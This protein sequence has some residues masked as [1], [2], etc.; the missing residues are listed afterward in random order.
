MGEKNLCDYSFEAFECFWSEMRKYESRIAQLDIDFG[1]LESEADELFK[2]LEDD[3]SKNFNFDNEF[4]KK[5]I[6]LNAIL[7][8]FD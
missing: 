4:Q 2:M 1:F 3:K 5:N 7:K 6:T 8:R